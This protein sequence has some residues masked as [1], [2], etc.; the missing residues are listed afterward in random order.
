MEVYT[1]LSNKK[2]L[3]AKVIKTSDAEL[4]VTSGCWAVCCRIRKASECLTKICMWGVSAV[5]ALTGLTGV[6]GA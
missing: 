6:A 1:A 5:G 4:H 2:M 3:A